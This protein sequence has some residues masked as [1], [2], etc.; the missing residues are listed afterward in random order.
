MI[1]KNTSFFIL[2]I[3]TSCSHPEAE[4]FKR[5]NEKVD[6]ISTDE[7]SIS[8]NNIIKFKTEHGVK[9]VWIEINGIPMRFIF[10][11]G[12]SSICISAAEAVF[13]FKQGTLE[14]SDILN[15]ELFQDATGKIS[16]GTKI[17]LKSVKVGN[18][19]IKNVEALVVEN[20]KAPLLLGQTIF[21]QFRKIQIDNNKQEITFE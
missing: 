5:D 21:K 2:L 12:A 20:E 19:I 11:T 14:K 17:N 3:Y 1:K 6:L 18:K 9:Y 8:K 4:D 13:L 15:K 16:Q 7:S 10:D